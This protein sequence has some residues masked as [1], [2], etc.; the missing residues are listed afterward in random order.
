MTLINLKLKKNSIILGISP[1]FN[2]DIAS[3]CEHRIRPDSV[4]AAN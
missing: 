4:T 3:R 1:T 2:F